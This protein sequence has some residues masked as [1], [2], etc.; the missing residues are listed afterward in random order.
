MRDKAVLVFKY[1]KCCYLKK[2]FVLWDSRR[3]VN[4]TDGEKVNARKDLLK[5]E[6]LKNGHFLHRI[7]LF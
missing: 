7:V 6:L 3:P 4:G 1:G 2:K 5:K